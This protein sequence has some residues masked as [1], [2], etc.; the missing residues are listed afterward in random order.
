MLCKTVFLQKKYFFILLFFFSN[1]KKTNFNFL[2]QSC[3]SS[4]VRVKRP[5]NAFM[6]F[7]YY[8]R[9]RL[10]AECPE[11]QNIQ[12]SK[13]L[14]RRWNNLTDEQR[15]PFVRESERLRELHTKEYPN[16]KYKP[17][18]KRKSRGKLSPTSSEANLAGSSSM[19][20]PT[21]SSWTN[22]VSGISISQGQRGVL[23]SL[24]PNRLHQRVIIDKN[25]KDAL[26]RT[27]SSNSIKKSPGF[28][29]LGGATLSSALRG[30]NCEDVSWRLSQSVP[31][32]P[33]LLIPKQ[34]PIST[35]SNSCPTTP[36]N[37]LAMRGS[38][39]VSPYSWSTKDPTL[40]SHPVLSAG[41]R[42][43]CTTLPGIIIRSSIPAQSNLTSIL[44]DS[45]Y[46]VS[47]SS[48]YPVELKPIT[49][50]SPRKLHKSMITTS[51]STLEASASSITT[52]I[53]MPSGSTTRNQQPQTYILTGNQQSSSSSPIFI[54]PHGRANNSNQLEDS[55]L[56]SADITNQSG[57]SMEISSD[58][59][60]Q[61]GDSIEETSGR[62]HQ[63][64]G[65]DLPDLNDIFS[66]ALDPDL[67]LSWSDNQ[68]ENL[69]L[70]SE[71]LN[72]Q[73]EDLELQGGDW[74]EKNLFSNMMQ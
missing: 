59:T 6:V 46:P 63:T 21:I 53:S 25:F 19:T 67:M 41:G 50:V 33:E 32:S 34:S 60:N 4:P 11:L 62:M 61:S 66:T 37:M 48:S 69:N 68:L 24:N 44:M 40:S 14:G 27:S 26:R 35:P 73:S 8:E 28:V 3:K 74:L 71:E 64:G 65:D 54:L 39:P 30:G 5:M 45:S 13:E 18:A 7:S 38:I 58:P 70:Q 43:T 51:S 1:E 23:K 29:A 10:V 42:S 2:F 55:I 15:Q 52:T 22:K 56:E 72:I 16:Y 31:T 47:S 9:K 49:V 57:E 12:L 36:V 17:A 20:S